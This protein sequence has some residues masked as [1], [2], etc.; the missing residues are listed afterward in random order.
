MSEYFL[1]IAVASSPE[2]DKGVAYRDREREITVRYTSLCT[3]DCVES[4]FILFIN[5]YINIVHNNFKY[6]KKDA[7]VHN[8]V[9]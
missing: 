3:V 1:L 4:E 7:H 6:P 9:I 5:L 8:Y 2:N